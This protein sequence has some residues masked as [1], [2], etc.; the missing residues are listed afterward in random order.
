[1]SVKDFWSNL[2]TGLIKIL[3]NVKETQSNQLGSPKSIL[4][5]RQHNQFGDL[6]ASVSLFRAVKETYPDS[7]LT[8]IASP[9]N[10]YAVVKNK[11][12]DELFVFEKSKILNYSYF[13]RL[14]DLLKRK[15]DLAITPS[16]VSISF[17]SLLLMRLAN[18]K[19]RIGVNSLNGKPNKYNFLFDRRVDLN[20]SAKPDAHVSDFILDL[21][22][23]FGISTNDFSSSVDFTEEDIRTAKEF[24]TGLGKT[25]NEKLIGLHVGAGKP[26]NRWSLDKYIELI[27]KLNSEFQVKFYLTGSNS[28]DEEITY[29]KNNLGMEIGIFLNRSIPELAALISESDLFITNDTGV[30]HVAGTTK[31]PQVS[32]FGPTNPFNWAPI[33][34]NKYFIRKS[35]LIDD[36]KVSDVFPVCKQILLNEKVEINEFSGN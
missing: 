7:H 10:Y 23:P 29:V 3:L 14:R 5:V 4:I 25:G 35:D 12:I 21:V 36:V 32:I 8:V 15:Y 19:I 27:R 17:T 11:F 33:G 13:N 9:Q 24:I 1:M 26:K 6:L 20:W 18:S 34:S 2:I 31:T 28:D 16:T 22:R 30:M